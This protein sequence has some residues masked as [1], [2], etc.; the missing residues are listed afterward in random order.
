MHESVAWALHAVL[1]AK[2][3]EGPVGEDIS[4]GTALRSLRSLLHFA[5]K[6]ALVKEWQPWKQLH[7]M[8]HLPQLFWSAEGS[9]RL[10]VFVNKKTSSHV[11]WYI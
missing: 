11:Y 3:F 4:A 9:K 7:H 10:D 2:T 6:K 5:V 1:N 8:A